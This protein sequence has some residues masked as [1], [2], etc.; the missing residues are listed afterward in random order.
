MGVA[1]AV[2]EKLALINSDFCNTDE[3]ANGCAASSTMLG[4]N[5][6][7]SFIMPG[8]RGGRDSP[9]NESKKCN[10]YFTLVW[11]ARSAIEVAG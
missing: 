5:N 3:N 11:M 2:A 1:W 9:G 10:A 6:S 7:H 8:W 4:F